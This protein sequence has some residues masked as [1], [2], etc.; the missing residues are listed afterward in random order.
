MK[1]R[2]NNNN[3]ETFR[4]SLLIKNKEN[5]KIIIIYAESILDNKSGVDFYI[6]SKNICFEIAPDL[7]IISSKINVKESSFTLNNDA[8]NY[9]SKNIYLGEI[10][11]ASPNYIID[12]K[13]NYNKN[14][15]SNE[16]RLIIDNSI[17]YVTL[18]NN[19]S[20][21]Y[22]MITMI[23]RIYS[24]YRITNLLST[25]NF[26]I[27]SQDNPGEYI[28]IDPM[29]QINFDF[30]HKGKNTPLLFS[31]N[32]LSNNNFNNEINNFAK[33]TSSFKLNDIGTYTFIIAEN[34]FNLE[35]RKSSK[36]DI[37]DVFVVETNLDNGKIIIDNL[38]NNIINI[39]QKNYGPLNQIIRGNEKQILNI[40]DQN[41]MEFFLKIGGDSQGRFEFIPSKIKQE[42]IEMGN[43][44][45]MCLESNGIKMK[46]CFYYKDV[47]NKYED[48]TTYYNYSV[49]INE[50]LVS[51]IGDNEFKNKNLRNY[52]RYE[53]L[54]LEMNNLFF[55]V[56]WDRN[57]GLLG[58]DT[59]NT[60]LDL[61][62]LYLYNQMNNR[63]KY[64][65]VLIT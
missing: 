46:V 5:K 13:N 57:I 9:R 17:S 61:E 25:K 63:V 30:F 20:K 36:K 6:K 55:E 38:T 15:H 59:L 12:L 58:K 50:V 35:I 52:K 4:L 44:I 41:C 23:Y 40:Y 21:K 34:M 39:C 27:A 10:L 26:V 64:I 53:I 65:K 32:N 48:K 14:Y 22:N 60:K 2:N 7:Y 49:K 54:L 43:N 28:S 62:K 45:V 18:K 8:Y 1:F 11:H 47:L 56:K 37:L 3:S 29:S 33:F 19:P 51:M 24:S 16:I 31:V 42:K